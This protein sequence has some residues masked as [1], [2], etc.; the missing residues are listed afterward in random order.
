MLAASSSN[1][2]S[3]N[4]P[5]P[6]FITPVIEKPTTESFNG[7]MTLYGS[8]L[9]N[10]K[11]NSFDDLS[12]SFGFSMGFS[13]SSIQNVFWNINVSGTHLTSNNFFNPMALN[14]GIGADYIFP[15]TTVLFPYTGLKVAVVM[16]MWEDGVNNPENMGTFEQNIS[17]LAQAD[18]GVIFNITDSPIAIGLAGSAGYV[19]KSF[20]YGATVV[21]YYKVLNQIYKDKENY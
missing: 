7:A 4:Y 9:L 5:Q 14:I 19:N 3:G 1:I 18:A 21:L 11:T 10:P 6:I 15:A 20:R 2:N 13:L 12:A 8:G 16:N 17:I